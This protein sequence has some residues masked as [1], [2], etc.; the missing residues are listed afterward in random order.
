MSQK[1]TKARNTKKTVKN[2][3]FKKLHVELLITVLTLLTQFITFTNPSTTILIIPAPYWSHQPLAPSLATVQ[4]RTVPSRSMEP[5]SKGTQLEISP[6]VLL[7][8]VGQ[9]E[10]AL[11]HSLITDT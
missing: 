2:S 8:P 5:V 9:T 11:T 10:M 6:S 7:S 3:I 4:R 1:I